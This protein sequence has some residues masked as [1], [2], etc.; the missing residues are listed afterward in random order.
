MTIGTTMPSRTATIAYKTIQTFR[1]QTLA[2]LPSRR[3]SS[4]SICPIYKWTI[5][6]PIGTYIIYKIELKLVQ[7]KF[8]L[9][10]L[11]F[12][13]AQLALILLLAV[14][15]LEDWTLL[16]PRQKLKGRRVRLFA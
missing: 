16:M 6:T 9:Y 13:T 2:A 8:I 10:N 5:Q 4:T 14:E 3:T 7:A 12:F 11:D 15:Q 1:F